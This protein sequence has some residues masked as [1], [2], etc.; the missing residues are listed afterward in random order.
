MKD[1]MLDEDFDLLIENGDFVIGESFEQEVTLIVQSTK[2]EWKNQPLIGAGIADYLLDNDF[3]GLK[4]E[5]KTQLKYDG[6]TLKN[7]QVDAYTI[8]IDA[9]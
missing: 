1:I 5:I 7:F 3:N 6:K 8:K 2:G 4:S 9:E